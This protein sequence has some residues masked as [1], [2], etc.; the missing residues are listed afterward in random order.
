M[1][2]VRTIKIEQL[3]T[4][5]AVFFT[6]EFGESWGYMGM[7]DYRTFEATES[8]G[9]RVVPFNKYSGRADNSDAGYVENSF[10]AD[11]FDKDMAN[12]IWWNIQHGISYKALSDELRKAG[13][14]RAEA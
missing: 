1:T 11:G 5:H 12:R 8:Y 4:T 2:E 9:V 14:I 13:Y 6:R 3:G 7:R 10:M